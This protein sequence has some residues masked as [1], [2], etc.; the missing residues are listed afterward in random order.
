[1][2]KKKK[3][4]EGGNFIICGEF[5]GAEEAAWKTCVCVC[6]CGLKFKR[7]RKG[8]NAGSAMGISFGVSL[9]RTSFG[10]HCKGVAGAVLQSNDIAIVEQYVI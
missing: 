8:C 1:V 10:E 4:L 2:F 3:R 7:R 5:S 9:E 6:V